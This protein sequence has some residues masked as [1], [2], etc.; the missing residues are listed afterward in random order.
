MKWRIKA[1]AQQLFSHLPAGE[2]LNRL[3]E[4][5]L[6]QQLTD[7]YLTEAVVAAR[8]YVRIADRYG[9][10]GETALDPWRLARAAQAGA[11]VTAMPR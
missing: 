4:R 8:E 2:Q 11:G 1:L 6:G 5:C 3:A 9:F 7:T 10:A